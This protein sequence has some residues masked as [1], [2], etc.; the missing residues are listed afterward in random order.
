MKD[1]IKIDIVS[2]VVCPW[3]II[4]Y[5]RLEKAISEL[6]IKDKVEIEWQP[7]ELN[8]NMPA[9]GQDV[10]EHIT[11][12]YGSTNEQQKRSQEQL[13]QLGAELDFKFDFFDG[14]KMVNTRD[15]HILLEYAKEFGNQTE[16]NLRLISA[17]FN[18]QKDVSDRQILME[19]LEN[20]GL[21]TEVGKVRLENIEA[22]EHVK[23]QE[24]NWQ[25]RGVSAVPTIVFNRTS[26]L[27]GARAVDVYKKVL[28]D[29][30]KK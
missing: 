11:Q 20:I 26:G 22:R 14:M 15:A 24:T 5:K 12:K 17:F 19:E 8:P 23:Q 27:T 28:A 6:G 9:E 7:F 13:T 18:E 1:K 3:C 16:L 2:D 29:L 30:I 10:Q 25:S 4:G 21:D